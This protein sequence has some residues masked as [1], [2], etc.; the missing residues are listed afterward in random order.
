MGSVTQNQ[1]EITEQRIG[2]GLVQKNDA[3]Q[4]KEEKKR[5]RESEGGLLVLSC[6]ARLSIA[7]SLW[8]K[9]VSSHGGFSN[10]SPAMRRDATGTEGADRN[11]NNC[12]HSRLDRR[13]LS[14]IKAK[15]LRELETRDR[16]SSS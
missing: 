2:G 1:G 16:M 11:G 13:S 15:I 9:D 8:R 4:R 10:G 7:I 6:L 5:R 12:M 3:T 14:N